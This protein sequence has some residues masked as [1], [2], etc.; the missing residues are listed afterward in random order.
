MFAKLLSILLV[1][2]VTFFW[3]L[4]GATGPLFFVIIIFYL[5][6]IAGIIFSGDKHNEKAGEKKLQDDR[7]DVD[8]DAELVQDEPTNL[9]PTR[10]CAKCG[11]PLMNE[12]TSLCHKCAAKLASS[13]GPSHN[14]KFC[15]SPI[16]KGSY[17]K[18]CQAKMAYTINHPP[19]WKR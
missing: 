18:N 6:I 13:D 17:C 12:K 5:Y 19:P 16:S 3:L 8:L 4:P 9:Q 14:C 7:E 10:Y 15:G 1:S 2:V 11:S